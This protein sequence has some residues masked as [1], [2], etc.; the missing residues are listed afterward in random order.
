MGQHNAVLF[1]YMCLQFISERI[2][3]RRAQMLIHSYI[4][5]KLD[6]AIISDDLWQ[7]YANELV[8]LQARYTLP[9]GF[10]D[11]VF[12]DWDASTGYHLPAD[13]WVIEKATYIIK[14]HSK[15]IKKHE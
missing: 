14:L 12:K 11:A 3:Q 1:F 2:K 5:Y 10:Y 8:T 4:Y 7:S 15:L 6:D 13:S 9:I